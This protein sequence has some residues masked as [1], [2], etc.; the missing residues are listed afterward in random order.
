MFISI[1][2]FYSAWQL[3]GV[4][5]YCKFVIELQALRMMGTSYKKR[6]SGG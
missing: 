6:A 1:S 2:L 5:E 3:E 4:I